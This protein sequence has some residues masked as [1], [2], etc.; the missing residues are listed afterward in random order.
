MSDIQIIRTMEELEALD[1]ETVTIDNEGTIESVSE[2]LD[3]SGK[4]Y[5]YDKCF[6]PAA[7]LAT[8][9]QVRAAREAMELDNG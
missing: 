2:W 7:V 3:D 6:L 9:D 5:P 8:G 4:A 1:P